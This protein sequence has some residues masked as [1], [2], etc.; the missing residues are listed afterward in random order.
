MPTEDGVQISP[1]LNLANG[2]QWVYEDKATTPDHPVTL[3]CVQP[4]S[5]HADWLQI[6]V[7][8]DHILPTIVMEVKEVPEREYLW[9]Q[10]SMSGTTLTWKGGLLLPAH[11]KVGEVR[12]ATS[13]QSAPIEWVPGDISLKLLDKPHPVP[14]ELH[15]PPGIVPPDTLVLDIAQTLRANQR[16]LTSG[17]LIFAKKIGLVAA[18][19]QN[20]G[21]WHV[22][23][24]KQW[25]GMH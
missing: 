20:F 4:V 17:T 9:L 6:T 18:N 24:L 1:F 15:L 22:L 7:T 16:T 23:R 14:P 25:S 12:T 3:S 5:N 13:A 2:H 11:W 21:V 19:V 8:P 10:A